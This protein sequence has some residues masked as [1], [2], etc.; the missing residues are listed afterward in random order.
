M[1]RYF[2]R[3]EMKENK[4]VIKINYDKTKARQSE[5]HPRMVTEWHVG[6][7][8][9]VLVLIFLAV[10][11]LIYRITSSEQIER[12][13]I[14]Q[15]TPVKKP[16]LIPTTKVGHSNVIPGN[17]AIETNA[18]KSD[19]ETITPTGTPSIIET[20]ASKVQPIIHSQ[21]NTLLKPLI[22]DKRISR[23]TLASGLNDKEPIGKVSLPI[24]VDK[25][26]AKGV[27]F[28]TEIN[29]MKGE[30]LF[31][32]WFRNG[33]PIFETN[34]EITILGNRWRA[35]TSKMIT[36]SGKGHWVVKLTDV[37]GNT[38]SEIQFDVIR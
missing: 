7:I 18:T 17:N 12:Q 19:Q 14:S 34:D 24:V 13:P 28:F 6:R 8:I 38:L 10:G 31:H 15:P 36:Y 1:A 20:K 22:V 11:Y 37:D 33:K 21:R 29:N 25:T 27:F 3:N 5:H 30:V 32:R 23:V 2:S 16:T 35:S 4:V 9:V 26:K